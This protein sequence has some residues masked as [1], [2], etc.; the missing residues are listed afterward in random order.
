MRW[1][2]V[3]LVTCVCLSVS[4][5][6]EK[7]AA[8]KAKAAPKKKEPSPSLR[9]VVDVPGLPRVLLWGDSISMGY[10][11][12]V[13]EELKGVANVHR[14][15][16]NCGPSNRG[17]EEMDKWIGDSKWDVIHFN[18]GLHDLKYID[19]N[20]RNTTPDKG[21]VQIPLDQY[22]A[23]LQKIAARLQKTGAKLIFAT[24]TP[25]PAGEPARIAGSEK[26][27]NEAAVKVMKKHNI[28]ID[29]LHAVIAGNP[30]KDKLF[31]SP[32][33]VHYHQEG[34]VLLAKQ[35]AASV[36]AALAAK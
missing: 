35:V 14:C 8:P 13:Q 18:H 5:A 26:S 36:K 24:T 23:N 4:L 16:T 29:D 9:P 3:L 32:G 10:T 6:Q 7:K 12:A 15:P 11:V 28:A 20:K 31:V 19:D 22:E 1:F 30:D 27:Y 25:V 21:K 33:N 2:T 17:V 34:S